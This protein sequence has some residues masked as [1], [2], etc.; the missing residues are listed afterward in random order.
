MRHSIQCG[1]TR[2]LVAALAACAGLGA[3]A[4]VTLP[5]LF[6][7]HAI[8]QRAKDTA[9]WGKATPGETVTVTLA[10][11]SATARAA[12]DG[13]WL[14]RLDTSNL[15]DGPFDLTAKGASGEVTSQDILVGEVWLAG[16]QSNMEFSMKSYGGVVD[17][18]Q[19]AAACKGR[20]IRMFKMS[21]RSENAPIKGDAK[22]VWRV[23][24]PETLGSVT[25]VGYMFIDTLQRQIGGAAGVVDISWSGTR[26]W[27][28][29]PRE[30]IDAHEELK[31]ER[32][33]QEALIA[34]GEGAK[35]RKPVLRCWNNMFYPVSKMSC[36]GIIW[37]QGCCDSGHRDSRHLYPK[38]LSYMVADMRRELGKPH[39]PF[40][41]CQ[42]A[43]WQHLP[44][45][46][47]ANPGPANLREGQRRAQKL[48][49]DSAMAVIL[50]NSEHE[51]HGRFKGPAGDRLAALALNRVYGRKEVVCKSPDFA[52]AT[53]GPSSADI[54]FDIEGSPLAAYALRES[55]TWNAKSNDVIRIVRRSSP[56]S[57]LEGF[58][59]RGADGKWRWADARI[60]GR[61]TVK[62]WADGAANPTA[63]RYNWGMQGFGNLYNAAG[64][65]ASCFTTEP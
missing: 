32:L 63:V 61:D 15:G 9:V 58:T 22:G 23:I 11:V 16:G 54:R 36:R 2:T 44:A 13:W 62:V 7:S 40:L 51:I 39:L 64:L 55:F 18:E 8:V 12:G 38:W 1:G 41:Y 53:F 56:A 37:Y 57:Q 47:D 43:G 10:G 35:V 19:R 27:A 42:L 17:Y 28:W 50:D 29:M 5:D 20:P 6:G 31:A 46:P 21:H 34:K 24:S 60:T 14:A 45:S 30:T 65:P 49:P 52:G 4:Q 26:C 3:S 59:I 48:I 25:A 33:H